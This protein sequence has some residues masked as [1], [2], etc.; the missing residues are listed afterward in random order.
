[1]VQLAIIEDISEVG[2]MLQ[3]YFSGIENFHPPFLATSAETFPCEKLHEIDIVLCDI[4]LPGM[5][6][7]NLTTQIK[8]FN[9][10]VKVVMFTV[11]DEKEK[12][13]Q[14][15]Q[16]GA[17]GYL[18]KSTS[19][20]KIK[21]TLLEVHENGV[22]INPII[23]SKTLDFFQKINSD[24]TKELSHSEHNILTLIEKGHS[25]NKISII[26][27]IQKKKIYQHINSVYDKLYITRIEEM[28]IYRNENQ[29]G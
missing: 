8:S 20:Q 13:F 28:K 18:L 25:L 6:G 22:T 19:L 27:K 12:I 16:A 5:S 4:N 3:L 10:N 21:E 1:M 9:P 2:K 26:L 14:S 15:F 24:L 29:V 11:F 17:S 7:I 23:A